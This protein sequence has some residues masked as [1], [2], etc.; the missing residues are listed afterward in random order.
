[1]ADMSVTL[2]A[3]LLCILKESFAFH[4]S[5]FK[6]HDISQESY[7]CH[8]GSIDLNLKHDN[9]QFYHFCVKLNTKICFSEVKIFIP[10]GWLINRLF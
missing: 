7:R 1:M 8:C 10:T 2:N 3:Q 6:K 5:N 4:F 9:L